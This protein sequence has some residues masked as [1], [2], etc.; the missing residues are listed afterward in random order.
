MIFLVGMSLQSCNSKSTEIKY[1]Y[2]YIVKIAGPETF[3]MIVLAKDSIYRKGDTI[4]VHKVTK[5]V[6]DNPM[7]SGN[8]A[9]KKCIVLE[10]LSKERISNE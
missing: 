9:Y 2:E 1:K 8:L 10:D 6:A 5:T 3:S 4:L 7:T